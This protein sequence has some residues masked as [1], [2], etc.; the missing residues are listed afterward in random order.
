MA[1]WVTNVQGVKFVGDAAFGSRGVTFTGVDRCLVSVAI[2]FGDTTEGVQGI[3]VAQV[4]EGSG[5]MLEMGEV[6]SRVGDNDVLQEEAV[7][8][9]AVWGVVGGVTTVQL[10]TEGGE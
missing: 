5:T 10:G 2:T 4:K 1:V 9:T 3:G 6:Q 8:T 7:R